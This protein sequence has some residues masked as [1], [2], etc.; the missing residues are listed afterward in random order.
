MK[1]TQSIWALQ[2]EIVPGTWHAAIKMKATAAA[3]T[4]RVIR[5]SERRAAGPGNDYLFA[6][7]TYFAGS[8]SK[9]S[10]QPA[11]QK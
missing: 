7:P 11:E 5:L 3:V 4:L 6:P 2:V 1:L 9:A 10:L 8:L